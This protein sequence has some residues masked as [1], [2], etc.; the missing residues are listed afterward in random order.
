[1][2]SQTPSFSV[3]QKVIEIKHVDLNSVLEMY[4]I[5]TE[6]M[7]SSQILKSCLKLSLILS[8]ELLEN[9]IELP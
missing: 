8:L 7:L 5:N 9:I 2:C 4:R 1:M 3:S 6:Y